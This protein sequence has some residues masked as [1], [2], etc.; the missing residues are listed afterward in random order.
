MHINENIAAIILIALVIIA[1]YGALFF[2]DPKD[3]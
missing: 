1:F 3:K 2:P